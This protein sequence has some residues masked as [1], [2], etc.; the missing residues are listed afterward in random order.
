MEQR[1]NYNL[2]LSI[3]ATTG[4][5]DAATDAVRNGADIN[6]QD[7][8]A[9]IEAIRADDL[10]MVHALVQLG[11]NVNQP[12]DG[13]WGKPLAVALEQR[14]ADIALYLVQHGANRNE[15][16]IDL[17]IKRSSTSY[18]HA[19][20]DA[21]A[22]IQATETQVSQA[23]SHKAGSVVL[24]LMQHSHE[25]TDAQVLTALYLDQHQVIS[26]LTHYTDYLPT[27]E[28]HDS[29]VGS[30]FEWFLHGIAKRELNKALNRVMTPKNKKELKKI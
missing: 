9:L 28:T 27:K 26:H 13:L 8:Q 6:H 17:A 16:A 20:E 2:H 24:Y 7:G 22:T 30:E 18:L 23:L 3:A 11:A 29:L 5:I 19:L 12:V 1:M 15:A 14:N 25:L 21:G 10:R 4:D